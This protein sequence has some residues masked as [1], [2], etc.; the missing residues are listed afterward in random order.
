MKAK[1]ILLVEPPFYRLI[2]STYA[3]CR[4]PLSLGCLAAAVLKSTEWEVLTANAD[5][6]PAADPFE[7][8]H[9]V[10]D[11][12]SK[13]LRNLRDLSSPVWREI[14]ECIAE[15]RPAVVG[16]S[17]KSSTFASASV[18]AAIA[19]RLDPGILVVAGGPHPSSAGTRLLDC[20][21]I[22]VGVAGEGEGTLPELL[23]TLEGGPGNDLARVRG[24]VYRKD[25]RAVSTPARPHIA[26][27]DSMDFPAVSAPLVLKDYHRYPRDAFRS[28]MA[29]RGCPNNCFFCGSRDIW[30]RT[31]RFRSPGNVAREIWS[32]REMGIGRV[33]F[34]DDT[35][36][37]HPGYLKALCRE[38]AEGC[39]GLEW[40]CETHVG[41][42]TDENAA[43]MKE[44]GCT[45]IQLGI[46]SGN[47][48]ILRAMRKGYTIEE[49]LKASEIVRKH[50]IALETFFMV[51]FP[52]ETEATLRDT[53]KAIEKVECAKVIYSIF[54]PYPGSEAFEWCRAEGLVDDGHDASVHHHQSPANNFCAALPHR[55]F[56]SIASELETIVD[57]KNR[58]ARSEKRKGTADG[59]ND[60]TYPRLHP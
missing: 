16:V 38:I 58:L 60:Q 26:D 46:E 48:D 32:L 2:R 8:H 21:H 35:F 54:T 49:A 24:I 40:S 17:T 28:V 14:E 36:G 51:G 10:G 50:G 11:G 29:T 6:L 27:L 39:P 47:N 41:L 33:H 55:I 37:V 7:V 56:R 30:G 42:I 25:G 15:Y 59:S 23:R 13:Y 57:A 45:T 12:F 4:Y 9:L 53:L 1:R 18:V 34:E 52:Q 31:V 3:L 19:K 5:F 44:A 43:L 20:P 22:D